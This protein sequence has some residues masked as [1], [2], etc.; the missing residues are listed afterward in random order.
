MLLGASPRTLNLL[1]LAD[2]VELTGRLAALPGVRAVGLTSNGLTL[3]RKLPALKEAGAWLRRA[4]GALGVVRMRVPP[5]GMRVLPPVQLTKALLAA[6][7]ARDTSTDRC[8]LFN[9]PRAQACRC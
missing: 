7:P 8:G 2:L 3:G 4:S 1:R 9:K 6:P 5:S